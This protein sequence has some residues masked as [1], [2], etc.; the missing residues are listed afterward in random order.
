MLSGYS[1]LMEDPGQSKAQE[2]PGE[3]GGT[4]REAIKVSYETT[5]A[6]FPGGDVLA[7]IDQK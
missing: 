1:L 7:H 5:K 3:I 6:A 2:N 4:W